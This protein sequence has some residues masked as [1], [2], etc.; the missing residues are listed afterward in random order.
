[1]VRFGGGLRC[2]G[3]KDGSHMA[4]ENATVPIVFN[5]T[6]PGGA[7]WMRASALIATARK[8]YLAGRRR[9][10]CGRVLGDLQPTPRTTRPAFARL[11]GTGD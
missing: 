3:K 11:T 7:V 4:N 10:H 6:G 2:H 5:R 9:A 8:S 1:M